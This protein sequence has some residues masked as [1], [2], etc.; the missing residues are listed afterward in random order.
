LL[1]D[2]IISSNE[3][4]KEKAPEE[5]LSGLGSSL[6]AVPSPLK[7]DP[8]T[9]PLDPDPDPAPKG[10]LTSA[11][12][13]EK[14]EVV[15]DGA[16]NGE[17]AAGFEKALSPVEGF[18]KGESPDLADAKPAKPPPPPPEN[19]LKPP[20]DEPLPVPSR[21]FP[22]VLGFPNGEAIVPKPDWPNAG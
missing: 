12:L 13:G 5:G 1:D 8:S 22:G 10:F 4:P 20:P 21:L 6:T 15:C 18:E 11:G 2:E 14:A 3:L 16:P 7:E 9:K 17:D 19:E